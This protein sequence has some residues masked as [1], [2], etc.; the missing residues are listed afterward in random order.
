[1][2]VGV[3]LL[4]LVPG[5]V[6]GSEEY[7]T[8]LL[9]GVA[10]R[11]PPDLRLT[12]FALAPFTRAYPQLVD[13]F[14]VVV[15]PLDG[16]SKLRRVLA[17]STW[18]ARRSAQ[19]R[20]DLV[21]HAGGTM[22]PV[23]GA[24]GIVTVHDLQPL[25]LPDNFAAVKHLYLRRRLG[26][27]VRE[28]VLVVTITA[29]TAR[30][31]VERLGADPDLVEIVPPAGTL[32]TLGTQGPADLGGDATAGAAVRAPTGRYFLYPAVTYPHKNHLL[33]VRAFARVA[34]VRD[35]VELVLTGG[36]AQMEAAVAAEAARLGV[37]DRVLR[38]G[39]V[40]RSDL[41]ALY[42]GATALTFPSR[43][44]GFGM[45]VLEAMEHGCPVI[46]AASTALPEV[47]AGAGVL[48]D[49]DDPQAWAA[50]MISVLDN[51][52][53]RDSLAAAGRARATRFRPEAGADRLIAVYRRAARIVAGAVV[54]PGAAAGDP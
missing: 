14:P 48:V 41:D 4:W 33:L 6:G 40:P 54:A 16:R 5:V 22:P 1:M 43:F 46:A 52:D 35:D 24:P 2:H 7:T 25:A 36:E 26:P 11:R 18:L 50:A 3:N 8:R 34:S 31:V 30:S 23:R 38:L 12:L 39:R 51:G 53:H 15:S 13:A 10:E 19:A 17:E 32:G 9:A 44:E 47:V 29:Y 42:R 28:A 45:P 20:L 49:P 21:H 27:S 37:S